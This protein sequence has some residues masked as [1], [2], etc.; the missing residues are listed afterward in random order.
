[1]SRLVQSGRQ[2]G[3]GKRK[4]FAFLEA[5]MRLHRFAEIAETG[6]VSGLEACRDGFQG[7]MF[8]EGALHQSFL[9]G[10]CEFNE[11]SGFLRP[12]MFSDFMMERESD[13]RGEALPVRRIRFCTL[14]KQECMMMFTGKLDQGWVAFHV[15]ITWRLW[16]PS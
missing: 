14:G 16:Q 8:G 5:Y 3:F 13:F 15:R 6:Q 7:F 4:K 9:P 10:P 11:K 12:E 2:Q 1:M